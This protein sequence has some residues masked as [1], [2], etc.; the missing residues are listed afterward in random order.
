MEGQ[1][2]EDSK[3]ALPDHQISMP[4]P[5]NYEVSPASSSWSDPMNW[6]IFDFRY[7]YREYF[8]EFWGTFILILFGDGVVATVTMNTSNAGSSY[9]AISFGW[10]IGLTMALY[11]SMGIS[12]GHLNPAVTVAN[13]IFGKF[14][15]RKVPGYMLA[16]LLGA[17]V[18]AATVY[19]IFKSQF[20]EFD[21]GNR[22]VSGEFGTGGIWCTYAKDGNGKFFSAFSEIVNT[23]VLLFVIYAI[24]DDRMTPAKN[25]LPIAI[26]LLV[27]AI[28]NCTGWV[29]GYAINP[30]RD[31]GPRIFSTILYGSEPFTAGGHYFW[32]PTFMPFVG[33]VVGIFCYQFFILPESKKR[34]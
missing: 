31:L 22:Q 10:G 15:W 20:D 33:A 16:Q 25:H 14:Q 17:F 4:E 3:S 30:A 24:G 19:G 5:V 6:P 11:V 28:G 9:L 32:V 13:A 8:A 29:T 2:H 23:A 34:N 26:G 12:G 7:K 1:Y 27:F 18:A 21:G